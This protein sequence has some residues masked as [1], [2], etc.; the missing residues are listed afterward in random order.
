MGRAIIVIFLGV[1]L[2]IVAA[3]HFDLLPGDRTDPLPKPLPPNDTVPVS[4]LGPDLYDLGKFKPIE[5]PKKRASTDPIVLHGVMNAFEVE[6]VPSKVQ[7]TVLFI[8]E[9][10]DD[11]AV[12]VAG[13][14]AFLAEPYYF[15][16]VFTG[17][18]T[19]VKFYRRLYEGQVVQQG[20]MLGMVDPPEALGGVLEKI[21]KIAAAEADYEASIAGEKEGDA[22]YRRAQLLHERK[23]ISAEDLGAALL[24]YIKLKNEMIS[25]REKVKLAEIEKDQADVKLRMHELRAVLPYKTYTIK[26]IHRPAG[27]FLKQLDPVVMTVQS[28]ERLLAEASIE[29]QYYTRFKDRK[30]VTATIEPTVL[31]APT[32]EWHGHDGDVTCVAVARDMRIVSG[33]EDRSVCVWKAHE[34]AMQRKFEHDE[35]VKALACSPKDAKDNL[36]VV[37]CG[38]GKIWLWDLDGD[39]NMPIKKLDKPHGHTAITAVAFSPDGEYFASGAEDGS[40]RLWTTATRELKYAFVPQN[41]VEHCHEDAVTSLHFTPQSRLISAGRD[42]TLRVWV[43]KKDGAT[44]DGKPLR[45]REGNVRNLGVSQDGQWMLFDQGR[46]LRFLSVEDR[47]LVHSINLPPNA[48]PFDTLTV[49]SPDGTLLL[50]AGAPE[51]RLQLW[52]TPLNSAGGQDAPARAFE[53]R[54]FAP[55]ERDRAVACAAFSPAK[56]LGDVQPFAVSGSGQKVYLWNLPDQDE[57]KKHRLENIPLTIKSQTLDTSTRTTRIGFEVANPPEPPRYPNGRFEAGRPVTIVID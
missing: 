44:P 39:K 25:A 10:V 28:L 18:Q 38:D 56:A 19:F 11:S 8:G 21:A 43:L 17:R 57:V 48:Q 47:K 6:E 3:W 42:K 1:A 33:S 29:E 13:S 2:A 26:T 37:G 27:T 55:R 32:H 30:H 16:T 20:Q 41:G 7:G 40:I 53:V 4:K 23:V 49:F 51:G 15:A 22:R 52:R 34:V 24:T 9:Q 36:C 35:P 5:M 45:D 50:T 12:L 31:E 54:Q 14:A 46:T